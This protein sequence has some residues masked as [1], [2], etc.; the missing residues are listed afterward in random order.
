MGNPI[1]KMHLKGFLEFFQLKFHS[2]SIISG[3]EVVEGPYV[4]TLALGLRPKQGL[5]RLRTKR[6]A[7]KS[8]HMLS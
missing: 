6:E 5:A 4:V 8:C 3:Y 7:Q 2:F 1:R